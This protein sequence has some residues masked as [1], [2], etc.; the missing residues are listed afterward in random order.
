[1][2]VYSVLKSTEALSW[3]GSTFEQLVLDIMSKLIKLFTQRSI[4]IDPSWD[5]I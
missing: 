1:M 3:F 2:S 4:D 5:A